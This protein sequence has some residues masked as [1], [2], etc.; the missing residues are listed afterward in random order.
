[1]L[2]TTF[3]PPSGFTQC[4][5]FL[6]RQL[7]DEMLSEVDYMVAGE[8]A[9]LKEAWANRRQP[10]VFF[11]ADCPE[12][13][14]V[15]VFMKLQA[16]SVAFLESPNDITGYVVRERGMA[17]TWAV[18]LTHQCLI[19]IG[20]L[21]ASD[22][23]LVLR[24]EYELTLGE[25]FRAIA[26]QFQ[27][28]ISDHQLAAIMRRADLDG[29]FTLDSPLEEVLLARWPH[30]RP[31]ER[32]LEGLSR[33]DA[34][35]IRAVNAGLKP[36]MAG[37][38]LEQIDWPQEMFIA[39]DPPNDILLGTIEMLG[40]A[41]CICYGPYLNLPMGS[42]TV[43]LEIEVRENFS[44]NHFDIDIFHGEVI[45]L[46]HFA[47]PVQGRF[48]L[49]AH[50]DVRDPREPIQLRIIM[51]EGAIEGLLDVRS[52]VVLADE[53]TSVRRASE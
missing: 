45:A 23:L 17:W 16:P 20:D 40:P 4:C 8:L 35:V 39:G 30:A 34:D 26:L 51:R 3:G 2:I 38:R 5:V 11:F 32:A 29:D 48:Q 7:T 1:M 37:R 6:M 43:S 9:Q 24:R 50:F 10:H 13:A 21:I 31:S 47:V 52:A 14:L 12:R 41:R 36:I 33:P 49:S 15:E 44:G 18:R 27:M 22:N 28:D 25:F 42:W 46:E 19:A 53:E